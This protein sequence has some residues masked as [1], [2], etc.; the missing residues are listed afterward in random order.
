MTKKRFLVFVMVLSTSL[1]FNSCNKEEFFD[2]QTWESESFTDHGYNNYKWKITLFFTGKQVNASLK[3]K[4]LD[5]GDLGTFK[6]KGTYIYDKQ[7][8]RINVEN[9]DYAIDD[10]WSGNVKKNT[11]TLNVV[12]DEMAIDEQV[13]FIKQ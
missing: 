9:D 4:D 10:T 6:A 2:G 1:V 3:W 5:F 12:I 11:M 13:V 7:K 8:V